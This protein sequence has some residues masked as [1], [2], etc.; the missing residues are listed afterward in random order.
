MWWEAPTNEAIRHILLILN[1]KSISTYLLGDAHTTS[2]PLAALLHSSALTFY[3]SRAMD[4]PVTHLTTW[5]STWSDKN[6]DKKTPQNN[7]FGLLESRMTE[8]KAQLL[9]FYLPLWQW[10][11]LFSECQFP[12]LPS[13][14]QSC[15]PSAGAQDLD[16]IPEWLWSTQEE[17]LAQVESSLPLG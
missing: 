6:K 4:D 1:P 13:E 16:C 5:R 17:H 12:H 3:I 9:P 11:V 7:S 15:I 10:A 14:A 2:F 8:C